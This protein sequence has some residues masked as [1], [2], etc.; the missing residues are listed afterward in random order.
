M[1]NLFCD[2][3]LAT[4]QAVTQA[5]FSAGKSY[6]RFQGP[7][8]EFFLE[9]EGFGFPGVDKVFKVHSKVQVFLIMSSGV[10][11]VLS[12]EIGVFIIYAYEKRGVAINFTMFAGLSVIFHP[13][14]FC[15][16]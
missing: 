12:G 11:M 8:I 15:M 2:E 16:K 3:P 9:F 1:P 10:I 7:V 13:S 6:G 5:A 14:A 4:T